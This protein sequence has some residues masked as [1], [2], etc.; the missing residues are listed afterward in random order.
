M[1]KH[2]INFKMIKKVFVTGGAGFI[3]SAL[4]RYLI[5]KTDYVVIN[6]DKLTYAGNLSSLASINS[7]PRYFFEKV[8]IT[9]IADLSPLFKKYKPN[10][11]LHLAA[12]SHVDRSIFGPS[13]FI[14]TNINGTFCLLEASLS[15]F[16]DLSNSE[17][18]SFLFHHIS[19]DEVYGDLSNGE[20]FTE[21]TP[22][23]PSSPYSASKAASDHLVRAWHRTYGLPVV[24]TNCSNNYGPY[25][26]PEKLI[27]KAILNALSSKEI[28]IYGNGEQVRDW[29]FVDDHIRAL[30]AVFTKGKI[31]E[32]YNIGGFNEKMNYEVVLIICDILERIANKHSF[33][34]KAGGPGFDKLIK[35]VS[36]RPGHDTRYAIDSSKI[37]NELGW[38]PKESFESGIEETVKWYLDNQE[39]SNNILNGSYLLEG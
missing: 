4:I 39:W 12:E 8:D 14:N 9:K 16:K 2:I 33:S 37:Y 31:G 6:I 36:D 22:Y 30:H 13:E 38:K 35:Y 29:L 3:G 34:K 20:F 11:V 21:N 1:V 28:P 32:T 10:I 23:K 26:F 7:N 5:N 19:T 18:K 17:M 25:Q 15:F 24:I 27:P